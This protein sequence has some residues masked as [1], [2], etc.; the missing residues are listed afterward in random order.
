MAPSFH[1]ARMG[2]W[3]R[4]LGTSIALVLTEGGLCGQADRHR[5]PYVLPSSRPQNGRGVILPP[6]TLL[7]QFVSPFDIKPGSDC[8]FQVPYASRTLAV[9]GSLP[10][11]RSLCWSLNSSASHS[12]DKAA[13]ITHGRLGSHHRLPNKRVARS[14]RSSHSCDGCTTTAPQLSQSS[15]FVQHRH[16][17]LLVYTKIP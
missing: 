8:L 2:I 14:A 12:S 17:T 3:T 16:Q 5:R 7:L 1:G 9:G 15:K 6:S 4:P 10:L 13:S 11:K